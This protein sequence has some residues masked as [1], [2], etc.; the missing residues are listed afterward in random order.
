MAQNCEWE[1]SDESAADGFYHDA[2]GLG[3]GDNLRQRMFRLANKVCAQT[4]RAR[5]VKF[6]RFDKFTFSQRVEDDPLVTGAKRA[7]F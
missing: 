1:T 5:F 7:P 3:I 2:A 6:G 4:I